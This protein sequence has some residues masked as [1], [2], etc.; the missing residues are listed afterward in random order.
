MSI[1]DTLKAQVAKDGDLRRNLEA[2]LAVAGDKAKDG[3]KGLG[4]LIERLKNSELADNVSSWISTNANKLPSGDQIARVL[5][6]DAI[7]KVA[8][9]LG[10]SAQ[11]AGDRVAHALPAV[12]D[13]I[14][15][16][17][18]LPENLDNIGKELAALMKTPKGRAIAGAAAVGVAAV[19]G[20]A[21]AVAARSKAKKPAAKPKAAA[22]PKPAAKSKA[23][24]KPA[25]KKPVAKKP[26]AKKPAAKKPAP[27]A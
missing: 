22:K 6:P 23:A 16:T 2:V 5:G 7:G 11:E 3:A 19:A 13:N 17:G 12:I 1:L 15:P 18:K 14:S 26:A 27:K 9:N 10:V 4:G 25:A 21:A 24:S 8:K 20:V